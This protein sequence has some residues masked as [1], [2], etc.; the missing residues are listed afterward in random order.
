MGSRCPHGFEVRDGRD[1]IKVHP[2]PPS[3]AS[4]HQLMELGIIAQ[5]K[6]LYRR[7]ML[8]EMI[9]AIENP[10]A[11]REQHRARPAG[12]KG[13]A[14]GHDPHGYV[15][16]RLSGKSRNAVDSDSI[17][18]C[19]AKSWILLATATCRPYATV[20]QDLQHRFKECYCF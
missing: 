4:I 8:G 13:L 19:W 12:R 14:E 6:L 3:C 5:R 18:R 16:A 1:R 11:Q 7:Y 2:L 10:K 20:N 17:A 9:E 15:I